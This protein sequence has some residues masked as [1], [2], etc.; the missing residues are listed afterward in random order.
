M[1]FR[2]LRFAATAALG[3]A[4]VFTASAAKAQE[5][6]IG[7][8]FTNQLFRFSS[9]TPGTVTSLGGAPASLTN[10]T[11]LAAGDFI[12]SIDFRPQTGLLYGLSQTNDT[13]NIFRLYTIDITTGAASLQSTLTPVAAPAG[14]GGSATP[15]P[16]SNGAIYTIDFNPVANALRVVNSQGGNYRI[17]AANLTTGTTFSDMMLSQ[18]GIAGVAY[19]NNFAGG[20][21]TQLFDVQT[22]STGNSTLFLQNPPN[23]GTL[24]SQGSTGFDFASGDLD[25]SGVTGLGYY[26]DFTNR[27]Y[28]FD[29]ITGSPTANFV[30]SFA[31]VGNVIGIAAPVGTAITAAPEPGTIALL[32]LGMVGGMGI[33]R[34]RR[35][36]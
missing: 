34:R 22:E 18:T 7:L 36:K 8:N 13:T 35:S 30:G 9:N 29:N 14:Q 3:L 2:T 17:G 1:Q 24:V 27:F 6:L 31:G 19:T 21:S 12:K 15:V 23:A 4:T 5:N 11:G 20:T 32:G 10:I 28:R 26:G 16:F 33:L 25:I